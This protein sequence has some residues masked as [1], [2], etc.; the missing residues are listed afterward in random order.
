MIACNCVRRHLFHQWWIIKRAHAGTEGDDEIHYFQ[1]ARRKQQILS[2]RDWAILI[3]PILN[4]MII[5][6]LGKSEFL[7]FKVHFSSSVFIKCFLFNLIG[8]HEFLSLFKLIWKIVIEYCQILNV[9]S[10]QTCKAFRCISGYTNWH[11]QTSFKA[12]VDVA[13]TCSWLQASPV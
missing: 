10:P 3:C 8:N 2:A 6:S 9:L 1:T 4:F 5:L 12:F 11:Y 7:G 13:I